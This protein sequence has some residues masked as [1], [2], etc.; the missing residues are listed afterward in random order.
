M[1]AYPL[2]RPLHEL[3]SAARGRVL[4]VLHA[5]PE[6]GVPLRE[7][8]RGAE[9][10]LSSV[11]RELKTLFSLGFLHKEAKGNRVLHR[12]KR[13][14][15]MVKLLWATVTALGL[16]G[17]QLKGMPSDRNAELALVRLCAH[18]PPD[19][20]L[21]RQFGDPRFLA[22]LAVTLAGHSGFDRP[23]YLALAESLASGS[24]TL[25]QY[26]AWYRAHRPGFARILSMI[27]RERRSYARSEYK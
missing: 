23:A 3:T 18:F 22:G 9:L 16:R 26:E 27:D 13:E 6:T 25:E 1:A 14:E 11:Q 7:L 21:W 24:S 4:E 17:V 15:P 19:A 5:G 10:S 20:G 8:A 12:L 2:A